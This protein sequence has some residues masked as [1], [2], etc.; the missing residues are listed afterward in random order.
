M[1]TA[2]HSADVTQTQKVPVVAPKKQPK[3]KAAVWV[4]P[5]QV[6]AKDPGSPLTWKWNAQDT[7]IGAALAAELKGEQS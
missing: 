2:K 4:D 6:K 1:S 3:S 5:S 7:P